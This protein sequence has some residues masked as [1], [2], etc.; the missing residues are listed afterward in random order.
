MDIGTYND[1][2]VLR[3]VSI[4]VFLG[5]NEGNDVLLP[6][7]YEPEGVKVGDTIRVFLYRDSED[8][9]IATTLQP[10]ITLN[11]FALLRVKMVGSNGAYLDWGLEKDLFVP[12]R[13]QN[14]KMEEGKYYLVFM[15][16]DP[17]TDRLV[18][19]AKINRF[20]DNKELAVQE[21][22]KVS[23]IAWEQTELGINVIVNRRHKGLLYHN[24][25]FKKI[26]VGEHLTGY[27]SKI[28]E[29]NKLDISLQKQGLS[30]LEE[31][32]SKILECLKNE[33]GFLALTDNSSPEEISEKLEMSKK[34]FK[35]AIGILYKN[36]KITLDNDGITLLDK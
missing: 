26:T 10:D 12:F 17:M 25:I 21:G 22:D 4:G 28:R 13:E 18:A 36:K 1:L 11:S 14:K 23:L 29:D 3:I 5:D 20:L 2:E 6:R 35:K 24:E 16:L 9:L 7:K 32:A 15:F 19:S 33:K 30:N 8:R 34:S 27:V 31:G